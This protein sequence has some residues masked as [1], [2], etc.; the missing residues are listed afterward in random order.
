MRDHNEELGL[1]VGGIAPCVLKRSII[2]LLYHGNYGQ[3]WTSEITKNR[4][5]LTPGLNNTPS[6]GYPYESNAIYLEEIH[7]E[8]TEF[9]TSRLFSYD[10]RPWE[11]SLEVPS[12]GH[13]WTQTSHRA[14]KNMRKCLSC[15]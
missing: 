15:S 12:P 14:W 6:R 5:R 13:S 9:Y 8:L 2:M 7:P 3:T 10:N 4:G 1:Y 11:R